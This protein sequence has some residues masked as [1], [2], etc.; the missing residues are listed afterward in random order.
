MKISY[1]T[2]SKTGRRPN[3]EDAFMT[4]GLPQNECWMGIICDGMGGHEMGEVAS[5]TIVK[6]I[7]DYWVRH[8]NVHD[9]E[10]KV[11][12]ACKKAS[13][14]IDERSSALNHC[15]MGTTMVMASI[16]DNRVTIA[17]IGDS[18]CYLVRPDNNGINN[19]NESHVL[20]QTKDHTCINFGREFV[21][22]CFFSY[23]PEKAVPEIAQFDIQSGDHLFLCSDGVYKCI[24]PDILKEYIL[25]DKSPKEI[26][27][28]ITN[29]CELD[30]DDN[31]TAIMVKID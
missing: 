7:T 13:V 12:K 19:T 9:D 14:D 23:R 4:I 29:L 15:Q 8:S 18:R 22:K 24:A 31:Y 20:Y 1:S 21:T 3:N 11:I 16:E 5:E 25:E 6:S 2:I 28:A 10:G 17:H 30:G 26:L 27:D